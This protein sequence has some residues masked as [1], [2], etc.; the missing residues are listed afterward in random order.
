MFRTTNG[1]IL[2]SEYLDVIIEYL[3][4]N[5][6]LN[7]KITSV[8]E[9][10]RHNPYSKTSEEVYSIEYTSANTTDLHNIHIS[11]NYIKS[12]IRDRKINKLIDG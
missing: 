9:G 12:V 8:M 10:T 2:P 7:P 3:L 1:Y 11:I 6:A 5:G 4:N